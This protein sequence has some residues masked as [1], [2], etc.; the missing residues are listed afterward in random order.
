[1]LKKV[2]VIQKI[3]K[4]SARQP[5]IKIEKAGG[6]GVEIVKEGNCATLVQD[7]SAAPCSDEVPGVAFS[8]GTEY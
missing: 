1:M 3:Q 6:D 5:V 7:D 8:S 2:K 4:P